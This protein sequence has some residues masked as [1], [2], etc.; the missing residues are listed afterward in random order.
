MILWNPLRI[1]KYLYPGLICNV[2]TNKQTVYL[3]FD[4]G[5]TVDI[6]TK[7]LEILKRYRARATFFCSGRNAERNQDI[8]SNIV[9]EGHAVGNHTYSHLKGWYT[10]NHIYYADIEM[11]SR[12]IPSGLFRP[13]YG[14]I[15]PS[16][17]RYLRQYYKIIMWSLLSYD[18]HPHITKEQCLNY[19]MKNTKS[20]YIVVFH[21]SLKASQ[22]MLYALPRVLDYF[23]ERGYIFESLVKNHY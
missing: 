17:I 15:K 16:Q 8:L 5:P 14:L 19:V 11:A 20:G 18:Y 1:A 6:S 12:F 4:D 2:S 10:S 3:T 23:S 13:P 21:D 22:N 7:V 9:Q